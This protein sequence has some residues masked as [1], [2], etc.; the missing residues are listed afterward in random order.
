MDFPLKNMVLFIQYTHTHTYFQEQ[1]N[2]SFYDL[3]MDLKL[4]INIKMEN[5]QQYVLKFT[6]HCEYFIKAFKKF[7]MAHK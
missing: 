1:L 7:V 6:S 4:Q 2:L 3:R 5:I